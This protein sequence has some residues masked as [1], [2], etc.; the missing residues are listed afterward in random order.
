MN[1]KLKYTIEAPYKD[2]LIR[3]RGIDNIPSFLNPTVDDLSAPGL[4]GAQECAQ[5]AELISSMAGCKAITIVDS[6]CDG[7]CASTILLNYLS[8][9]Y[10]DWK[11]DY[12]IHSKKQH[13][14]E[15]IVMDPQYVL[16]DY[17]LV[18]LP[19]AGSNDD[20]YFEQYAG[21]KFIILDHHIRSKT[22][23]I[24]SNAIII[25]N[26]VSECYPNKSLS[27]AGV[28]WQF[29]R[30]L[31]G[32]FGAECANDFMDLAAVAII[33]DVM[34]ITTPENRF[35][36]SEGLKQ[37]SSGQY[38]NEF[39][40]LLFDNAAFSLNGTLTP[41]GVAFYIVPMIN[42]MC[43]MGNLGE[44]TRMFLAFSAPHTQV[45]CHKRGVEKGTIVDVATE[46]VRECT[47]SK[48]RQKKMQTQMAEL[49]EKQI[50]EN[51]LM[52]NKILTI[53]L[54]ED[55]DEMPSEMNGLTA[56]KIAN[57]YG[58]PTIIGRVNKDGFLRGSMRGLA[59]VDMPPLK[60]F[61]MSSGLFEY[62]EGHQLAAG[63]S[64]PVSKLDQFHKWAN[65]ELSDVHMDSKT[66]FVDF[67][68]PASHPDLKAVICSMDELSHYWGQ[69]FSEALIAV[70][71]IRVGRGD[72]T[73]MGKNADTVKIMHNGV[74]YMF[75]KRSPEEVKALTQYARAELTIVG[76]A[77]L[78]VYYGRMTPQIFVNDYEIKDDTL[79]F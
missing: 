35:I 70:N 15:D 62:V 73:V 58:H 25:N 52:S 54:D 5:A 68:M 20:E 49:C 2:N 16:D 39:L 22:T 30:Y 53:V 78:N 77:N 56:T 79:G 66:W 27:G 32:V 69:G 61:F 76:T 33:G 67:E 3:A 4:L 59:T 37:M 51:D 60:E 46:S 26:Q 64:I 18:F 19:D 50:I 47:N 23:P 31:D 55:F 48:A 72:I 6:D 29:C 36:I 12:Y 21:T 1:I 40:K 11:I 9:I 7:Y 34:D 13:G 44:K 65:E 63:V 17:D 41:I 42:S 43:R 14:L 28:T 24:P 38:R 57:D 8:R 74:A 45:E 75:F 10:P 71:K